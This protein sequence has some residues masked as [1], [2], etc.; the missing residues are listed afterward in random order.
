MEINTGLLGVIMGCMFSGKS[1]EL[2]ERLEDIAHDTIFCTIKYKNDIRYTREP[3]LTTHDEIMF[4]CENAFHT[5]HLMDLVP[6]ILES[7]IQTIGVD[8]GQFFPD[9]NEFCELMINDYGKNVVVAGLSG[10]AKRKPFGQMNDILSHADSVTWLYAECGEFVCG[11]DYSE[12]SKMCRRP[13]PFTKS[14]KNPEGKIQIGGAE[15]YTPVCRYH[16]YSINN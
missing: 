12:S 14:E 4:E 6:N 13:A 8:E 5:Q 2:I 1:S 15:I 7:K 11:D 9:L 3:F 10:N 16:Y